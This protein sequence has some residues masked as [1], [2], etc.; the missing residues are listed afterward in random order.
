MTVYTC[1][2]VYTYACDVVSHG[3]ISSF[4]HAC[5][6]YTLELSSLGDVA[7]I[8][9]RVEC[10]KCVSKYIVGVVVVTKEEERYVGIYQAGGKGREEGGRGQGEGGRREGMEKVK[11]VAKEGH[12]RGVS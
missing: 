4:L 7:I 5:I 6:I 1:I 9:Q 8:P 11:E 2:H 3:G 12:K 10:R